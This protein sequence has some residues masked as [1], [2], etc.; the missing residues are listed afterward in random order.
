MTTQIIL[1]EEERGKLLAALADAPD[2]ILLDAVRQK[3]EWRCRIQS[4]FEQLKG[5]IGARKLVDA[6]PVPAHPSKVEEAPAVESKPLVNKKP[7]G[8]ATKSIK[9]A[10]EEK[11][12][13]LL[14][15]PRDA[16]EI[17]RCLSAPLEHATNLLR[18]LWERGKITFD[19]KFYQNAQ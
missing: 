5:F 2:E 17:R 6:A 12:A 19:G 18:L 10:T 1:T 16:E 15:H 13:K 8:T 14:V 3:K 7:P 4:D 9:S 11:L